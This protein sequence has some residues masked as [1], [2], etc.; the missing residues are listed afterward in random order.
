MTRMDRPEF[1]R[2]LIAPARAGWAAALAVAISL[3]SLARAG[4]DAFLT[5]AALPS[6]LT[7]LS[8]EQLLNIEVTSVSKRPEKL[9]SA[10]AAIYVLTGDQIRR[11]GARGIADALRLVPGLQVAQVDARTYA[12]SARGFNS[13]SSDKLQ[14]LLDG[15]TV[16]TPL[17]SAVFWD[18]LDTYMDDIERIEV[19]RGPGATLW[20]ANAVNGVIN[21]VTRNARDTVGTVVSAGGGTEERAA[22][23]TPLTSAVFWDVLDTYMDDIERIEVIRGPGATLW[24]ANAVNG[25]INIVTRNARDTVGTVVSAGGGTE[26][27]AAAALRS[28]TQ[29]GHDGAVRFYAKSTDRDS[30]QF[31][32]GGDGGDSSRSTQGGFRGDWAPLPGKNLTVSGDLYSARFNTPPTSSQPA[33]QTTTASGANVLARWASGDGEPSGWTLQ[34]YYDHYQRYIP[35][36][37]SEDRDT[38]DLDFQ[39]RLQWTEGNTVMYG[40][41]YRNSRDRTGKAPEVAVVFLPTSRT[42]DTTSAFVQDQQTLLDGR[43]VVTVGSKFEYNDFTGFEAQPGVRVGWQVADSAF[44]WAAISR[45]LR[46]PNRLDSDVAIYCP[47][48]DGFPGVC[49]P[50][51]FGLGNPK[52]ESEALIAY[53]WGLRMWSESQLTLDLATFYNRYDRL[54]SQEGASASSPF[55]SLGNGYRLDGYGGELV[56][57]WNP[58]PKLGFQASYSLLKLNAEA[59]PGST[60]TETG[61]TL[62]GSSPQHQAGLRISANPADRWSVDAFLRYVGSL[63]AYEVPAYTEL[64][65]RAAYQIRPSIELSLTGKNLLSSQHAEFGSSNAQQSIERGAFLELRWAW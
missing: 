35:T 37:Y 14:V 51:L 38:L 17:T 15:R 30:S 50:G 23:Y 13:S 31:T 54:R 19:I 26:E 62:E 55:G 29:V 21:I 4:D 53:E 48:P 27:R 44:T 59:K 34:A 56:L 57:G 33:N 60:D 11:S 6:D 58:D 18:V 16:Y 52:F 5:V 65:L 25:V 3:P 24:G 45:A 22:A 36:V 20:G 28:G 64:D 10:A 39:Q 40:V 32:D 42:L 43:V 63:P 9:S 2:R 1:A 47:E 49:G 8:L 61:A 41:G 7:E 12:I 46:T